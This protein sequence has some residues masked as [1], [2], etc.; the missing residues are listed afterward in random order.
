[1]AQALATLPGPKPVFHAYGVP[2]EPYSRS[3]SLDYM[4][5][6]MGDLRQIVLGMLKGNER[7]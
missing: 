5:E 6:M 2:D 3:G 1:M 7:K 4:R